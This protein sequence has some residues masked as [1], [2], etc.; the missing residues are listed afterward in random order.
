[1]T[2]TPLAQ[3]KLL[4][5]ETGDAAAGEACAAI[6]APRAFTDEEL[7]S[8]LDLRA[9]DVHQAAYDVLLKKAVSTKI[10]MAGLTTAEQQKYWLRLAAHV[11]RNVGRA[12]ERADAP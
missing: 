1:M 6:S 12:A 8:F 7:T 2:L 11:R 9:G 5:L 10:T 3:L 4:T